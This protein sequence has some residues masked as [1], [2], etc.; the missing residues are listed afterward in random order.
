[1]IRV[2]ESQELNGVISIVIE[3]RHWYWPWLRRAEY[4]A[5]A[6]LNRYTYSFIADLL[7]ELLDKSYDWV[8]SKTG[9]SVSAA[10]A[11]KLTRAFQEFEY[12]ETLLRRLEQGYDN[13]IEIDEKKRKGA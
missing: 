2:V 4:I 10:L 3:R 8:S 5:T 1:M 7:N 13:V 12:R 9:V 11:I 6:K